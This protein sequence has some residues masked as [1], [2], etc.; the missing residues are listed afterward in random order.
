MQRKKKKS[1]RAPDLLFL[2][3]YYEILQVHSPDNNF[4]KQTNNNNKGKQ[5]LPEFRPNFNIVPAPSHHTPMDLWKE[6]NA[7]DYNHQS[8]FSSN[9]NRLVTQSP[10][11][12]LLF[13]FGGKNLS[14]AQLMSN[15]RLRAHGTKVM[16]TV[17]VA[18]D[19]LD[20]LDALVGV[21]KDLAAR[22]V[23][24]NVTKQHLEVSIPLPEKNRGKSL[25]SARFPTR[26]IS[27]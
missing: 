10:H 1:C 8:L 3:F 5:V 27:F 25:T 19:S 16:E 22:H 23:G 6:D 12:G 17:G 11:A 20:D 21:I 18:V 26:W 9:S 14:S 24:Y 13:P 15:D 2:I 7:H 4:D